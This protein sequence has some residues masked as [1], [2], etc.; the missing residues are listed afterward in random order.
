[1]HAQKRGHSR[2]EKNCRYMPPNGMKEKDVYSGA[3]GGDYAGADWPI[4]KTD[5]EGADRRDSS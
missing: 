2:L 3:V 4:R 1:M 5:C